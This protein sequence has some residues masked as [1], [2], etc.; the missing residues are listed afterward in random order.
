MPTTYSIPCASCCGGGGISTLC[1]DVP[2]PSTLTLSFTNGPA[3]LLAHTITLVN[4]AGIPCGLTAT[5][6]QTWSATFGPWCTE[7]DA[8]GVCV[9]CDSITNQWTAGMSTTPICFNLTGTPSTISCNPFV[10]TYL[11]V[12]VYAGCGGGTVDVII[13]G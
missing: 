10:L 6:D 4:N 5:A 8:N 11:G 2:V 13:T 7:T 1:C 12:T 3:C 9:G